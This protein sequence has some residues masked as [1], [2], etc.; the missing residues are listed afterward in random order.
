MILLLNDSVSDAPAKNLSYQCSGS[1]KGSS[2]IRGL[3]A[4]LP[5]ARLLSPSVGLPTPL[6]F[7]QWITHNI[8]QEVEL[9]K[10]ALQTMFSLSSSPSS[11]SWR[12]TNRV[13]KPFTPWLLFL[14]HKGIICC[15][16]ILG[17]WRWMS[18]LGFDYVWL[19]SA[20][21]MTN[22]G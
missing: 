19:Q 20:V 18:H 8:I 7:P 5:W 4:V 2:V 22:F 9:V 15:S 12:I 21:K 6:A 16:K 17:V 10:V 1:E 14:S 13:L 11:P 3:W